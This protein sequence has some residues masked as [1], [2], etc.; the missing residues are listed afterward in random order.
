MERSEGN[1][2][3]M[4]YLVAEIRAGQLGSQA[5]FQL[6]SG[7]A[8]FYAEHATPWRDHDTTKW[9]TLYAPLFATLAAQEPI[10][11]D[12]LVQWAG[13]TAP[14]SEV[15]HLLR[16]AR[17]FVLESEDPQRGTVYALHHH[18]LRD[19]AMGRVDR[20]RLSMSTLDV[21]DDLHEQTLK[22]HHRIV[23]YYRQRRG[24]SWSRLNGHDYADRHL[25]YHIEQSKARRMKG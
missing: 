7:L 9:N 5:P 20:G 8:N 21:L 15:K 11:L 10:P 2:R 13:V 16:E 3:Y 25:A 23:E 18:S 17:P 24:E 1:W 4:A 19:F 22:A 6:P 12:L 14:W